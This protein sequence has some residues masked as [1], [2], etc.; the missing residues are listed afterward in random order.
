MTIKLP[1]LPYAKDAL[2]P[3][4]SASTLEF[5]H[6]KHHAAYVANTNKLIA[7]TELEGKSLEQII[8]A[9]KDKKGLFNNAAQAWNHDFLWH[10][11]SPDGGGAAQGA[12][13]KRIEQ[14]FKSMESFAEAFSAAAMGQFGSGWAW[15]VVNGNKLE[16]EATA[17]ADTPIAHGKVPLLTLDVWEHAYYLDYQNRRADYVKTFLDKLVN[18]EFANANLAKAK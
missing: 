18:W 3:H 13:A 6:D 4:I 5:H 14:E 8:A 16:I 11:M 12:V 9:A 15:L 17:N 10:S 2:A 1:D 7:G